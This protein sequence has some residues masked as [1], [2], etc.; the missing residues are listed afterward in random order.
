MFGGERLRN[1]LGWV[2]ASQ[3]KLLNWRVARVSKQVIAAENHLNFALM[4]PGI[5][6]QQTRDALTEVQKL[7][8]F[9]RVLLY[10]PPRDTKDV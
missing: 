8:N 7:K 9:R 5:D 10:V 6:S 1:T 3:Q 4:F 2:V